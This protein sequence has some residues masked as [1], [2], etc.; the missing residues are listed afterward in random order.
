MKS[1]FSNGAR[2]FYADLSDAFGRIY[3]EVKI[4]CRWQRRDHEVLFSVKIQCRLKQPLQNAAFLKFVRN[5]ALER[6][7]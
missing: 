3:G 2:L 1:R 5:P 6:R 7:G 4:Q